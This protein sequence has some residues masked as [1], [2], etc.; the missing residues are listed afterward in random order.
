[1]G[2]AV[3]QADRQ[4]DRQAGMH[5][6]M[7]AGRQASRQAGRQAGRQTRMHAGR[8]A[9]R[10]AGRQAGRQAGK[11]LC[12]FKPKQYEGCILR[13]GLGSQFIICVCPF[14]VL[15]SRL[16][17]YAPLLFLYLSHWGVG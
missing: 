12:N 13:L 2:H 16:R 11:T 8:H 6:C 5:V 9:C 3:R 7:Q 1:V 10:H 15:V 17:G 14:G 4:A